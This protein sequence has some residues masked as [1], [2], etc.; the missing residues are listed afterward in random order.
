MSKFAKAGSDFDCETLNFYFFK[1]FDPKLIERV[2]KHPNLHTQ[3]RRCLDK[4]VKKMILNHVEFVNFQDPDP[5]FQE[6]Y[7]VHNLG[8]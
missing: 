4:P 6:D 2:L 5:H 3:L 1:H 7:Y 8:Q